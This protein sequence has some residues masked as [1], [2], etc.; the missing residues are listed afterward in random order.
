MQAVIL[1]VVAALDGAAGIQRVA[2]V[3]LAGA[4]PARVDDDPDADARNFLVPVIHDLRARAAELHGVPAG[5]DIEERREADDRALLLVLPDG[6]ADLEGGEEAV[7][8]L[9]ARR[10]PSSDGL[11][12]LRVDKSRTREILESIWQQGGEAVSV[13]PARASLEEMFLDLAQA[14]EKGDRA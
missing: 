5:A 9:N 2:P 12:R 6:D 11:V 13:N 8:A 4:M 1:H 10:L 7:V 14:A 3:E